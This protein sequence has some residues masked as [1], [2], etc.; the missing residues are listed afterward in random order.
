MTDTNTNANPDSN[1]YIDPQISE[2]ISADSVEITEISDSE[3]TLNSNDSQVLGSHDSDSQEL[4]ANT[5]ELDQ[6]EETPEPQMKKVDIVIAGNTY[7]IYCPI[8]EEEALRSAVYVINNAVLDI[9]EQAPNLT[10]ENLLVLCCLNLQEKVHSQQKDI[11]QHYQN[12][13]QSQMLLNKVIEDAES[14]LL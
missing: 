1:D 7:P 8:N 5:T 13:E 2:N 6:A 12:I 4:E 10:Q 14:V 9:K 11:E 3:L